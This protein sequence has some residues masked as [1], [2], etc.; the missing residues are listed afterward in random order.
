[1]RVKAPSITLSKVSA[2]QFKVTIKNVDG[3]E[4]IDIENLDYRVRTVS[5]NADYPAATKVCV[6]E[7]INLSVCAVGQDFGKVVTA[8]AGGVVTLDK[9]EEKVYYI[10]VDGT[11]IEPE[12][13]RA[14][15]SSLSY[16]KEGD[17]TATE[18]YN[19]IAQ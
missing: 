15:I 19:V 11:F 18:N 10:L 5:A 6:T 16:A 14:D 17:L 4:K 12:V 7:D 1:L 13:L 3:D 8:L 2:N 9:N